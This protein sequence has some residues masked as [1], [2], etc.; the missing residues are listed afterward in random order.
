ME[1][2]DKLQ[3]VTKEQAIKLKKLGFD[4]P[5]QYYYPKNGELLQGGFGVQDWKMEGEYAAPEIQ[6][7]FKWLKNIKNF[8]YCLNIKNGLFELQYQGVFFKIDDYGIDF[9][10]YS[11]WY[12]SNEEVESKSLDLILEKITLPF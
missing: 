2:K 10:Y 11:K 9:C 7:V 4:W 1:L 12:F 3:I 5:T 8:V 6:L